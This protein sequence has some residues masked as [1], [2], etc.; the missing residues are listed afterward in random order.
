MRAKL[1][2]SDDEDE[3]F[4][5]YPYPEDEKTWAYAGDINIENIKPTM[6]DA[7]LY[8]ITDNEVAV[9]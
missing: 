9:L 1:Y 5:S 2:G 6:C 3:D 8:I 7:S 4:D